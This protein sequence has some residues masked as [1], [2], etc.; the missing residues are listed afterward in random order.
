MEMKSYI[1]IVFINVYVTL[2]I[3]IYIYIQ[4][5]CMYVCLVVHTHICSC[6]FVFGLLLC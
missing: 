3:Y 2:Y 5:I 4:Y 1:Y 6:F